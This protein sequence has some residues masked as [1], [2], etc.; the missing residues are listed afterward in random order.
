MSFKCVPQLIN[1]DDFRWETSNDNPAKSA[2]V[3]V[4]EWRGNKVKTGDFRK[5]ELVTQ[6]VESQFWSQIEMHQTHS[7]LERASF[8]YDRDSDWLF[9]RLEPLI[10][11]GKNA[12]M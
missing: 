4:T 5:R 7:D 2:L 10:I 11:K 3:K 9:M 6:R 8:V 12:I 1:F